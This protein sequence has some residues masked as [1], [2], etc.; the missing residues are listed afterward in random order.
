MQLA[1]GR[2]ELRDAFDDPSR[3]VRDGF[4]KVV[5][6]R[7]V[8]R[9]GHWSGRERAVRG[10]APNLD[11]RA[12]GEREPD[13][14]DSPGAVH[15][16]GQCAG[17]A[18][19]GRR[20]ELARGDVHMVDA[21]QVVVG[22]DPQGHLGQER[23]AQVRQER[24][25]VR[26]PATEGT[27]N[28][29]ACRPVPHHGRQRGDE[30]AHG[31]VGV[32]RHAGLA[33]RRDRAAVTVDRQDP[34]DGDG[35]GRGCRG[36]AVP[37]RLEEV[38]ER[39]HRR[40]GLHPNRGR[41]TRRGGRLDPHRVQVSSRVDQD[42]SGGPPGPGGHGQRRPGMPEPTSPHGVAVR[43]RPV[44]DA[45]HVIRRPGSAR[46]KIVG[47]DG[48]VPVLVDLPVQLDRTRKIRRDCGPRQRM[49]RGY[50]LGRNPCAAGQ[51][52]R[53]CKYPTA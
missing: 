32:A 13:D 36:H 5:R 46:P 1:V 18:T 14:H 42:D 12:A 8:V 9:R 17:S 29:P 38:E 27:F 53:A 19:A 44:H 52:G 3:E 10:D 39:L 50:Q 11:P 4:R 48:T 45:D 7:I 30:V 37:V 23:S 21:A 49:S 2:A 35:A 31:A 41:A 24:L 16:V 33:P 15:E 25:A 34:P 20:E 22:A 47:P 6:E 51:C 40:A 28:I 26:V 43:M